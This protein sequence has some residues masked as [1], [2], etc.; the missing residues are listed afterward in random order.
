MLLNNI[1]IIHGPGTDFVKTKLF[2]ELMKVFDIYAV[3][4]A[5]FENNE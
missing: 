1:I 2:N 5:N 3:K 4:A